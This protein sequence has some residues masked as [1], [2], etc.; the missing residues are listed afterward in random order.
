MTNKQVYDIGR[1]FRELFNKTKHHRTRPEWTQ[2]I[3]QVLYDIGCKRELAV[4]TNGV[5]E[6]P[7]TQWLW[8]VVWAEQ[9]DLDY[10]KTGEHPIHKLILICESEWLLDR[11]NVMRDF[12]KLT[13]GLA[14]VKLY[15]Y[16][17]Y[18]KEEKPRKKD[19]SSTVL[20]SECVKKLIPKSKQDTSH[21]I[22]IGIQ[23]A[24]PFKLKIEIF[25]NK[26]GVLRPIPFQQ[27]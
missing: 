26:G 21:Y 18:G 12:Q 23:T 6:A 5:D 2:E 7:W 3:R 17:I 27:G 16:R 22:F 9:D 10:T 1:K 8:D 4:Y 11:S 15:I 13:V 14:E 25:R 19:L 20:V 24:R